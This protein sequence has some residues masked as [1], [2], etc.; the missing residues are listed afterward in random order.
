MGWA[1]TMADIPPMNRLPYPREHSCNGAPAIDK[2]PSTQPKKTETESMFEDEM[3][4]LEAA[5]RAADLKAARSTA[6]HNE[7]IA[8][9]QEALHAQR[10]IGHTPKGLH[11]PTVYVPAPTKRSL[12]VPLQST[13]IVGLFDKSGRLAH[14]PA[15][16]LAGEVVTLDSALIANSR[17]AQAGARVFVRKDGSKLHKVGNDFVA[18]ERA[19]GRFVNVDAAEF[20]TIAFEDDDA[21]TSP[22]PVYSADYEKE[23][24]QSAMK[25]VRFE[26]KRSDRREVGAEEFYAELMTSLALGM[27]RAA[28]EVLLTAITATVPAAYT[29]AAVAA[30]GLR[31]SDLRCLVG[32][33]GNGSPA[34]ADGFHRVAGIPCELTPDMAGTIVGA[35]D[36]VGVAVGE[37]ADVVFERINGNGTLSATAWISMLPVVPDAGK[38]WTVV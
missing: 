9:A 14:T 8:L 26:V 24:A 16:A 1:A 29:P 32:T 12:I 18:T 38:F 15:G 21:P 2:R 3:E 30:K 33:N 36:R 27:A 20:V 7:V 35:W 22:I 31:F 11:E 25:A 17:V 10:M 5:Q 13:N 37:E 6:L 34:Y 4:R 28:D 23:W 19:S